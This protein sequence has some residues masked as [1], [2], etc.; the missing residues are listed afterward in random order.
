MQP[1]QPKSNKDNLTGLQNYAHYSGLAF[2]MI[3]IIL[4]FVWGGKRIDEFYFQGHS[5]FIIVLS[6]IGV[7]IAMYIALKDLLK[8][9]RKK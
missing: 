9:T 3:T 2:Q 7:F 1:K 6:L 8:I 5:I 4:V